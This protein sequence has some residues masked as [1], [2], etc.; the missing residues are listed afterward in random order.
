NDKSSENTVKMLI[1]AG[2]DLVIGHGPHVLRAFELYKNK[3][4]AYSLGN[5]LTY[6]NINISGVTGKTAIVELSIDL[7]TGDFLSGKIIPVVQIHT[8]IPVYDDSKDGIEL[9]NK[10]TGEDFPESEIFFSSNGY[11]YDEKIDITT[12]GSQLVNEQYFNFVNSGK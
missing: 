3:F 2:A 6:G 1:D 12:K 8:G 9:I 5:F 10:L 4:I 7:N 11:F